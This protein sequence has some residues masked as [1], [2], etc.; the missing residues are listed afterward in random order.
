MLTSQASRTYF[1]C[2]FAP[3]HKN[4]P[5][6]R[7]VSSNNRMNKKIWQLTI[8]DIAESPVWYFPMSDDEDF[9]EENVLPANLGHASDPNTLVVVATDFLDAKGQT[10]LGYIYW[11]EAELGYS[12]PCMFFNGIAVTFW[13]GMIQPKSDS[14]PKVNFPIT[15]V[16]RA[17][18]GLESITLNISGYGYLNEKNESCWVNC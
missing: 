7:G 9:D 3:K 10:Y 1:C 14:L 15:A 2:R 6:L 12:Q 11:G 16:S 18:L 13:F 8:Q 5:L 17:E 4:T